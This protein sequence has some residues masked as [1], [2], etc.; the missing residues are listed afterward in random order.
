MTQLS[1]AQSAPVGTCS[2]VQLQHPLPGRLAANW[3]ESAANASAVNTLLHKEDFQ[4]A[5]QGPALLAVANKP[6][7][8]RLG[9]LDAALPQQARLGVLDAAPPRQALCQPLLQQGSPAA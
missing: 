7:Q 3:S 9:V 1:V 2:L 5:A 4:Q 6:Q 8:A